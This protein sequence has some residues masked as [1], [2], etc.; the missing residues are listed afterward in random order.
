MEVKPLMTNRFS[1]N[2]PSSTSPNRQPLLLSTMSPLQLHRSRFLLAAV[3]LST[4][5]CDPSFLLRTVDGF[6]AVACPVTR[7][8][9]NSPT[10]SITPSSFLL[11]LAARRD[12][13][14]DDYYDEEDDN[15]NADFEYVRVRRGSGGR[16]YVNDDDDDTD[17]GYANTGRSRRSRQY[18]ILEA[19]DRLEDE[20]FLDDEEEEEEYGILSDALIPNA[21]LDNMD[22]DGAADRFPELARDPK[23]WFDM[24]LVFVILDFISF[25]GPRNPFPG[26][27]VSDMAQAG[28]PP[29]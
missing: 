19:A 21:L 22:P 23:F 2:I 26:E 20:G 1:V 24:V 10:R 8:P 6:A 5:L 13:N 9:V 14:R 11:L 4:T 29:P 17:D 3:V 18:D 12:E 7:P 16:R 25:L 27:F 15:D 28:L